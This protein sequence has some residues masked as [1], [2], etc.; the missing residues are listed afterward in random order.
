MGLD[1]DKLMGSASNAA[2]DLQ[3]QLRAGLYR[4]KVVGNET[5]ARVSLTPSWIEDGSALPGALRVSPSLLDVVEAPGTTVAVVSED[6][7]PA[8]PLVIGAVSDETTPTTARYSWV[9]ALLHEVAKRGHLEL[10]AVSGVRVKVG[11]NTGDVA[12]AAD[13]IILQVGTQEARLALAGT[14]AVETSAGE[15]VA[16]LVEALGAAQDL[17]AGLALV[18]NAID[19]AA[20]ASGAVAVT[21]S[22][23]AGFFNTGLDAATRNAA[24]AKIDAALVKLATF[25][26]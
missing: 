24:A 12:P 25:V 16:E 6:G 14:F 21:N 3:R 1:L 8:R 22:T 15:L 9:R 26:E 5:F 13:Q 19:A 2:R 17:L 10:G 11:T 4:A 23:L 18:G 20:L 7:L